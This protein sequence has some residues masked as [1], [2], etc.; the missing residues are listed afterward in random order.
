MFFFD[1]NM[2]KKSLVV[3]QLVDSGGRR[4]LT[5]MS[6]S[7][8]TSDGVLSVLAFT[9]TVVNVIQTPVAPRLNRSQQVFKREYLILGQH[10]PRL[11]NLCVCVG[12]TAPS[13]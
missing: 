10:C 9:E 1:K 6:S 3:V 11:G 8:R 13:V 5:R 4:D 2:Q 12:A 7:L